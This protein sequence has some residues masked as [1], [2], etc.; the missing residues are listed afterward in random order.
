MRSV[1]LISFYKSYKM[2]QTV[3]LWF[4]ANYVE[5][6]GMVFG[7]VY[8]FFSIRQNIWLWPIGLITSIFYIVIFFTSKL[9]AD[10]SLQIYYLVISIYGWIHWLY[11]K[12]KSESGELRVLKTSIKSW[13]TVFAGTTVLSILIAWI[14]KNYTDSPLPWW[15]AFLTASSIMATWMLAQKYLENWLVWIAVDAISIG[16]FAYKELYL[17]CIL[18]LVYTIMAIKGYFEWKKSLRND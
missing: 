5:F 18:F 1:G 4:R 14:L 11:G 7:I 17:T 9:Y 2:L 10:M 12:Q 13:M 6:F 16:V 8:I 3:L 15:D